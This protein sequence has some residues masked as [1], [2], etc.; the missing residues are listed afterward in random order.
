M[1]C[2]G[3]TA[4]VH[5]W[6]GLWC[7]THWRPFTCYIYHCNF[8]PFVTSIHFTQC[9]SSLSGN[10]TSGTIIKNRLQYCQSLANPARCLTFGP[11]FSCMLSTSNWKMIFILVSRG[12][13]TS[14]S[15][16]D[17]HC[18]KCMLVTNDKRLC[19]YRIYTGNFPIYIGTTPIDLYRNKLPVQDSELT[20]LV[21]FPDVV[22][23]AAFRFLRWQ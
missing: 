20:V 8:L 22:C 10:I 7:V 5:R 9:S 3:S 17:V 16:W 11:W 4:A 6:L 21:L 1:I 14:D 2:G 12:N 13:I 15:L 19:K 18:V 23:R